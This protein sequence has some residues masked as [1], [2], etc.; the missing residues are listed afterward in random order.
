MSAIFGSA[1][2]PPSSVPLAFFFSEYCRTS[3]TPFFTVA[4]EPRWICIS[5]SGTRNT[6]SPETLAARASETDAY[7]V[8]PMTAPPVSASELG[9]DRSGMRHKATAKADNRT[10]T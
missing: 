9:S 8:L 5:L 7:S 10:R 3:L 6:T 1:F 2:S 4:S